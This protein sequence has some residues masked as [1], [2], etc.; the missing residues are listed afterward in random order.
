MD[1]D[2]AVHIAHDPVAGCHF[3]PS[4]DRGVSSP[5]PQRAPADS[6]H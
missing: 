1:G 2:H 6:E 5:F 3:L 4:D